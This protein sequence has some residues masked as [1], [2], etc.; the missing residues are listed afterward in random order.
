M[1][2]LFVDNH[3]EFTATVIASFLREH[4]VVVVPTIAGAKER[5]AASAFDVL[6][7]DYDLDDGKGD[8]L[9]RWLR[10]TDSGARIIAVSARDRGNE[11]LVAAGANRVCPKI[12]FARIQAVL[13]EVV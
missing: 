7:V 12:G 2:I 5:L 8:E 4:E 13:Q 10:G 11:A 9:V 3:P 1:R 6:L